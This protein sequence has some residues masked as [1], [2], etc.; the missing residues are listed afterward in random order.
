M[1][2]WILQNRKNTEHAIYYLNFIYVIE[3][4]GS[5]E[6][7]FTERGR[8]RRGGK[9][10]EEEEEEVLTTLQTCSRLERMNLESSF[11]VWFCN[12]LN[13]AYRILKDKKLTEGY[14]GLGI[15]KAVRDSKAGLR[16]IQTA[17]PEV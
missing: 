14:H 5:E 13:Q 2:V 8:V 7:I 10:E 11:A 16:T 17:D 12:V 4:K 6:C 1:L 3:I 9:W 15:V